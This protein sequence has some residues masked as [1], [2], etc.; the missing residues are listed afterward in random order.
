VGK[1][2]DTLRE[3]RVALGLTIDQVQEGTRIRGKLIDAIEDGQYDR[4][5][6]PGYVRGYISSYARFLELDPV[7]LLNMYKAETG[8]GRQH[9]VNIPQAEEAVKPTGQQHAIP[10]RAAVAVALV[11]AVLSLAI[12]AV[13]RIWSG[14]EP[15]PPAPSTVTETASPASD[16]AETGAEPET[17]AEKADETANPVVKPEPKPAVEEQPFTLAVRVASDGASWLRV[18]VDGKTAYEGVLAG[19]Q[20]KEFEVTEKAK[21]RVGKPEAVTILRDGEEVN[22][23]DTGD[24]GTVTLSA[25]AIAQ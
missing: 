15:T 2:G 21:I 18:T 7:P 4:L 17:D 20:S 9:L 19:G 14:P 8:A 25:K 6:D 16:T 5:P 13:T 24:I 12:W 1:L 10:W 11:V 3:R 23:Q 22:L